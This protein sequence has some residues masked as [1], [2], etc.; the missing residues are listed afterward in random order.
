MKD[1]I[2]MSG[3]TPASRRR[4]DSGLSSVAPNSAI[5]SVRGKLG[6]LV[7][8]VFFYQELT[9]GGEKYGASQLSRGACSSISGRRTR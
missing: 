4:R 5:A 9:Q 8:G 3:I 2:E 6:V 1:F 7:A